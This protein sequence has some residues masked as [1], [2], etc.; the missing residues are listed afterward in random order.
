M[1]FQT[2]VNVMPRKKRVGLMYP[3]GPEY[4]RGEDRSQGNIIQSTATVMRAPN[5]MGYAA[6]T[7][8]KAGFDVFFRDFQTRRESA[9]DV[10][11]AFNEFSPDALLVSITNSTIE[12]DLSLVSDLKRRWPGLLIVLKGALFWDAPDV[13]LDQLNLGD[14]DYLI[15]GEIEFTCAKLFQIHFEG[16]Q[17]DLAALSGIAY[18]QKGQWIK[19]KFGDFERHFEDL[20]HPA[21]HHMEN[22]LYVRPDTGAPQAT[23]ATSRGCP[24]AARAV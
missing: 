9:E 5:D 22:N 17:E 24:A 13:V 21:R 23:I 1:T 20:P 10:F 11:N 8:E 4:Q 2:S 12:D 7:L 18:R 6:A 14:V 19:T 16:R 15:G 3:P